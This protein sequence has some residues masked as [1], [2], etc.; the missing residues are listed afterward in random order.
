MSKGNSG[1]FHSKTGT[2]WDYI[3]PTQPNY[4]DTELPR[5][6]NIDTEVGQIW[7]H[8]HG[9]MHM[10]T[11]INTISMSGM[12]PLLRIFAKNYYTQLL[13]EDFRNTLNIAFAKG[14]KFGI[15][16]QGNW[17]IG[18]DTPKKGGKNPV[19]YHAVFLGWG[20]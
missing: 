18:I 5:S 17:H 9:T 2:V 14:I 13:L 16:K 7:V 12:S 6:F 20:H 11:E 3:H 4:P 19:I 15:I 8:G 10:E 1:L